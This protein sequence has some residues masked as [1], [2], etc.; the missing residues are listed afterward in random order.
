[1]LPEPQ[2]ERRRRLCLPLRERVG[3]VVDQ[4]VHRCPGAADLAVGVVDQRRRRVP[5]FGKDFARGLGEPQRE[6]G[7]V[8][9]PLRPQGLESRRRALPGVP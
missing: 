8:A 3:G 6:N 2:G 1:M 4:R 5:F 9:V 7:G